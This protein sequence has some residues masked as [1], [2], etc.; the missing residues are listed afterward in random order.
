MIPAVFLPRKDEPVLGGPEDLLL[1]VEA[2]EDTSHAAV[3]VPH[4]PGP[5]RGHVRDVDRP[6]L[7]FPARRKG[8]GIAGRRDA[9]VGDLSAVRRP[10]RRD[11]AVDGRIEIANRL[12]RDIDDADERV[13]AA[14]GHEGELRSV[15]R[16]AECVPVA[17]RCNERL[18][19]RARAERHEHQLFLGHEGHAIAARRY[20][21]CVA[22]SQFARLAV[23]DVDDVD[24][25]CHAFR[26][27][28]RIRPFGSPK[29]EIATVRVDDR[30]SVRS[31]GKLAKVLAV[32]GRDIRE[33]PPRELRPVSHPD[34]PCAPL[35]QHPSHARLPRRRNEVRRKRRAED[36]LDE[37]GFGRPEHRGNQRQ[38]ARSREREQSPE[39]LRRFPF[40]LST[41]HSALGTQHSLHALAAM[42]VTFAGFF[43]PITQLPWKMAPS[44]MIR[45]GVSMSL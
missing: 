32:I 39:R 3:G 20:R 31:E 15:R 30:V 13:L 28:P 44:S 5:T 23:R 41:R 6:R 38:E 11:V 21:R 25:L 10:D 24:R 14:A 12:R 4:A 2:A 9:Q 45:A 27:A 17:R 1:R 34:V 19:F 36:V 16:P 33:T 37:E 29:L 35:V 43:S 22:V 40:H 26:H 8:Q 42:F 7:P 18:G